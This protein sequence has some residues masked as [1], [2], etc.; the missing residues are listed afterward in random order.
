[1]CSSNIPN[2]M[3]QAIGVVVTNIVVELTPEDAALFVEFRRRQD[4]FRTLSDQGVFNLRNG[5][6]I[7]NFNAD[8]VLTRISKDYVEWERTKQ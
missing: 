2:N 8:G 4:L 6:A 7:L 3:K 5:K 1:M